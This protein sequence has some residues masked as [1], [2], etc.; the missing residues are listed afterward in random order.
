MEDFTGRRLDKVNR[1][2]KYHRSKRVVISSKS[3]NLFP[4]ANRI[5]IEMAPFPAGV[6]TK[7]TLEF[8]R[9]LG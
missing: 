9:I 5:P 1:Y 2:H 4:S 3:T 7:I 6:Y 8:T